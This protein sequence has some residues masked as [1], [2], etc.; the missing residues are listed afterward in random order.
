MSKKEGPM[1]EKATFGA[2]CFWGVQAKFKKI[3]GV[4]STLAGYEGGTLPNPTYEDVCSNTT[5][6]A[7]VVQVEFDPKKVSYQD[8]LK[9]FWLMHDPTTMH[10]QGPDIGSQYRSVIFY[11]SQI[12]KDLASSM[13]QDLERSGKFKK[14]IVTEIFPAAIF[15]PAEEYHQNYLEKHGRGVDCS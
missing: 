11:H 10:R 9:A 3:P 2:G 6:H 8:L 7:E 13:K 14:P 4:L 5:G 12:Q 1:R 15:Y